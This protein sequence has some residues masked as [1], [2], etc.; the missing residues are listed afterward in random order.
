MTKLHMH[1]SELPTCT[2]GWQSTDKLI[3][4]AVASHF[5]MQVLRKLDYGILLR[6]LLFAQRNYQF[7]NLRRG[8]VFDFW[9]YDRPSRSLGLS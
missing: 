8:Y 6:C 7:A 9:T 4:D 1:V 2:E 3:F 5:R